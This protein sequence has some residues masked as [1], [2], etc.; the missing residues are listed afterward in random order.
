M[1]SKKNYADMEYGPG[2]RLRKIKEEQPKVRSI[3]RVVGEVHGMLTK[4][5]TQTELD[6]AKRDRRL[7]REGKSYKSPITKAASKLRRSVR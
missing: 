4:D 2:G 1:A 7:K 6:I 3:D 5:P